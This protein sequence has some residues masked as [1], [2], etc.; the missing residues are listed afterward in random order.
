VP[1]ITPECI[2]V[3]P[4]LLR[5]RSDTS[6]AAVAH[7]CYPGR[8]LTFRRWEGRSNAAAQGLRERGIRHGDFVLLLS[9]LRQ[10]PEIVVAYVAVQKA[11]AVPVLIDMDETTLPRLAAAPRIAAA[12]RLYSGSREIECSP[13]WEASLSTLEGGQSEKPLPLGPDNVSSAAH[14]V[15]TSGTTG[16]PKG[17]LVEHRDLVQG[18][19]SKVRSAPIIALHPRFAFR[20]GIE[21]MVSLLRRAGQLLTLDSFRADLF[22]EAVAQRPVREIS[23]FPYTAGQILSREDVGRSPVFPHVRRVSLTGAP[24]SQW[25]ASEFKRIFPNARIGIWYGQTEAGPAITYTEFSPDE[26]NRV[27]RPIPPTEVRIVDQNGN[28]LPAG[29]VGQ[30]CLRRPG[31]PHRR[32]WLRE[33]LQTTKYHSGWIFTGDLGYID[34]RGTLYL[35]DRYENTVVRG[36]HIIR[37]AEIEE[38]LLEHPLVQDVAVLPIRDAQVGEEIAIAV[39]LR[40]SVP[41]GSLRSFLSSRL[42]VYKM[43]RRIVEARAIPRTASGKV[44]RHKLRPLFDVDSNP[45]SPRSGD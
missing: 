6:P 45:G 41:I 27:G 8:V 10:W 31:V 37:I 14:V 25:I 30:I 15:F 32:Y 13:S 11:G 29:Q 28:E 7:E 21:A 18:R 16:D 42:P 9:D 12:V 39:V 3:L 2:A 19:L 1:H 17:V 5:Y 22:F 36:T 24:T 4:E 33:D 26:P 23:V 44:L 43:P 40:S 20:G 38:V 35:V 34:K